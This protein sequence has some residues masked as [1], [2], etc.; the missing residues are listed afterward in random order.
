MFVH[1]F[2]AIVCDGHILSPL[3]Q[4]AECDALVDNAIFDQQD[5]HR[6]QFRRVSLQIDIRVDVIR[7][8]HYTQKGIQQFRLNNRFG[9]I[10]LNAHGTAAIG[11]AR[12]RGRG[13]HDDLGAVQ[14]LVLSNSTR[15]GKAVHFW[16]HAV[17]QDNGKRS[18]LGRSDECLQRRHRH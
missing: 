7:T 8:S 10:A 1:R 15:D 4:K 6:W 11:V 17:K 3:L 16:H 5:L 14:V 13:N 18:R 2:P 9:Y 12:L